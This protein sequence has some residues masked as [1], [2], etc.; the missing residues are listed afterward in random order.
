MSKT[1][2]A[3]H[4]AV[5][6]DR[7]VSQKT[8]KH[9]DAPAVRG[10]QSVSELADQPPLIALS[11][12]TIVAGTAMRKPIVIRSGIRMLASHLIATG[13]KT[14]IKQ[15]IDRTR[16]AK[17]IDSGKHDFK[18][19]DSH[20]HDESS[21]PSGHTAG[22]VAVTRAVAQDVPQATVPGY[23]ISAGVA[24]A[25]L[26]SGKH[27]LLDTIAGAAIGYVGERV[28]SAAL[29]GA[30]AA[31]GRIRRRLPS[32]RRPDRFSPT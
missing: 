5:K 21:F 27:Y 30:E 2:Q 18:P 14:A 17:A 15:S 10:I 6:A 29:R 31:L 13:I 7:K 20:D 22:V 19:G 3:A 28:A 24:A 23:A 26:P 8:A 4:R 16:P 1:K 25:Q 32:A 12:A 11:V 9:R